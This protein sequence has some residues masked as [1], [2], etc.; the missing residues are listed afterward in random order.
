[1]YVR[2]TH[3]YA[4]VGQ[5]KVALTVSDDDNGSSVTRMMTV[6]VENAAPLITAVSLDKTTIN[7]D[8]T[9]LLRGSFTDTGVNETH[10]VVVNW[11]DDES[12]NAVVDPVTRTFTAQHQYVDNP[13]SNPPQYVIAVTVQDGDN[14]SDMESLNITVNNAVPVVNAGPDVTTVEAQSVAFTGSFTTPE[15]WTRIRYFGTSVTIERR[16]HAD[17]DTRVCRQWDVYGQADGDRR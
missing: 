14:R 16:W 4:R 9:V 12:S 5:F 11:G 17:A 2:W 13:A 1:V 10:S 3:T 15:P 6:L 7:E 8:E